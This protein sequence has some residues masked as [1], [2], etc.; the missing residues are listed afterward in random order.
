MTAAQGVPQRP[1]SE[2]FRFL[3]FPQCVCVCGGA[4]TGTGTGQGQ[5]QGQGGG[6]EE[7]GDGRFV[8]AHP[9]INRVS[10]RG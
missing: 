1:V 3:L 5:G 8:Q 6:A 9:K 4:G 2:T 7:R 10:E